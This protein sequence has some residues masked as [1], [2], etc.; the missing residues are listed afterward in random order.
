MLRPPTWTAENCEQ[1]VSL[2]AIPENRGQVVNGKDS[3]GWRRARH[4]IEE[5]PQQLALA[6]ELLLTDDGLR[7]DRPISVQVLGITSNSL[8]CQYKA[9]I[10]WDR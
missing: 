2:S 7:H 8:A 4:D 10:T 6:K 1:K 3:V 9:D 5:K